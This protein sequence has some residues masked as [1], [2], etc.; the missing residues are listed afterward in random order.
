[1][2]R[3]RK[4]KLV[5]RIG[6]SCFA[7]ILCIWSV[8]IVGI[9]GRFDR[10]WNLMVADGHLYF[11]SSTEPFGSD[12]TSGGPNVFYQCAH[13]ITGISVEDLAIRSDLDFPLFVDPPP[14]WK[15][16]LPDL[17]RVGSGD[18]WSNRK[19]GLALASLKTSPI[20]GLRYRGQRIR[21]DRTRLSIPLGSVVLVVTLLMIPMFWFTRRFPPGHCQQCNYDL[22][23]NTSHTCPECGTA[24]TA[25]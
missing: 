15:C 17:S 23:K 7:I 24:I 14:V 22:Y 11:H 18:F 25:D 4:N 5:R 10:Y 2:T 12:T 3:L 21:Y 1:M 20:F 8:S 19:V 13:S 9:V 16:V 6:L